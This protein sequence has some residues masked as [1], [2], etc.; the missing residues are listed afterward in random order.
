MKLQ[1]Q[2]Y[3]TIFFLLGLFFVIVFLAKIN[4]IHIESLDVGYIKRILHPEYPQGGISYDPQFHYN[5]IVAFVARVFGFESNSSGLAQIFWFIEQ[6]LT[7][8][9]LIKFC[10]NQGF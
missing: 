8:A 2:K 9:V 4:T 5:Y 1:Y 7:I 10:G 6:A 3:N